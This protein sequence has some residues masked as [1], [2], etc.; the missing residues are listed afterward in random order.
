MI[1]LGDSTVVLNATGVGTFNSGI[2]QSFKNNRISGNLTDG[3][4]IPAYAGPGGA[5]LQ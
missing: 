2:I 4:P 1:R 5:A 3:T